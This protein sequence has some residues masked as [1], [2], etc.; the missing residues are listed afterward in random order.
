MKIIL[1]ALFVFC[2]ILV[3]CQSQQPVSS[4]D[5]TSKSVQAK[6]PLQELMPTLYYYVPYL[7]PSADGFVAVQPLKNNQYA[8]DPTWEQLGAFLE[9]DK[10]EKIRY[11]DKAQPVTIDKD[12]ECSGNCDYDYF[13]CADFAITLHNNAEAQ[14]IRAGIAVVSFQNME[15]DHMLNVFDVV[16]V[17]TVYVDCSGTRECRGV[18][19]IN[20]IEVGKY[21]LVCEYDEALSIQEIYNSHHYT[22]EALINNIMPNGVVTDVKIYW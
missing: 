17:G 8:A 14:G 21:W 15:Y 2:F 6:L 1:V 11:W 22:N 19:R 3:G 5:N 18:D 7:K 12:C 16:G 10:T 4:S 20:F 9:K 13:T